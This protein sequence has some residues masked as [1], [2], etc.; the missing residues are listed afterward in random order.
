MLNH[1]NTESAD[2][3]KQSVPVAA[4][5]P[6]EGAALTLP[7]CDVM[8]LHNFTKDCAAHFEREKMSGP[9]I[10]PPKSSDMRNGES[11]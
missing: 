10:W 1:N 4:G 7:D 11:N 5:C 9:S 3:S 8:I 6:Q 2:A